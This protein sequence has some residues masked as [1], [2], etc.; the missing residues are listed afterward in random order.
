MDRFQ[1]MWVDQ[2][3]AGALQIA[4]QAE[5]IVGEIDMNREM[6]ITIHLSSGDGRLTA[7]MIEIYR[8]ILSKPMLDVFVRRNDKKEERDD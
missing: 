8:E 2:L 5:Q 4:D 1:K 6:R 3:R 7:P